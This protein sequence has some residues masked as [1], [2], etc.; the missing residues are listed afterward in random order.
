MKMNP[1]N[2]SADE[3]ANESQNI[4]GDSVLNSESD[5]DRDIS[6][7]AQQQLL[8]IGT[9]IEEILKDEARYVNEDIH[10]ISSLIHD[11]MA[12]LQQSFSH[13][14]DKTQKQN[15][16]IVKLIG[17]SRKID[18]AISDSEKD[19][20]SHVDI[21]GTQQKVSGVLNTLSET[22]ETIHD[23][24]N[25]SIRA[26]QFEDITRQLT[27]HIQKRLE[28]INEIALVAHTDIAGASTELELRNIADRLYNMRDNF[29]QMNI[30]DI[31]Q[32]QDMS[33]GDIDL[34]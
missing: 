10:R 25:N 24:I 8:K 29:R 31:V 28:H 23:E 20:S 13:V 1:Y 9:N 7:G 32:Q 11:S 16:N 2:E 15:I 18:A 33:E 30:A 14:M 6:V 21:S 26:L 12:V 22:S 27:E 34:F 4:K 19:G 3:L 5:S 17:Y